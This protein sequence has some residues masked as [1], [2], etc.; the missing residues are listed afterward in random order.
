MTARLRRNDALTLPL[1]FAWRAPICRSTNQKRAK[2]E[3]VASTLLG[4]GKYVTFRVSYKHLRRVWEGFGRPKIQVQRSGYIPASQ[5]KSKQIITGSRLHFSGQTPFHAYNPSHSPKEAAF[6]RRKE[7]DSN[8]R[9]CSYSASLGVQIFS[10]TAFRLYTAGPSPV[11]NR[12]K[13]GFFWSTQSLE[14][15]SKGY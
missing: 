6:L 14:S 2:A 15:G 9:D 7:E 10:S 4:G 3:G 11:L 8:S 1:P 5:W 13:S 12:L